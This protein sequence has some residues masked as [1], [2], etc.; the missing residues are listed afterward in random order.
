V[1][2]SG[3]IQ[4]EKPDRGK[5]AGIG[6]NEVAIYAPDGMDDQGIE[7]HLRRN[8]FHVS[9]YRDNQFLENQTGKALEA[10]VIVADTD[11]P[12]VAARVT[13]RFKETPVYASNPGREPAVLGVAKAHDIIVLDPSDEIGDLSRRLGVGTPRS[14]QA[15]PRALVVDDNS[16]DLEDVQKAINGLVD[17]DTA[18]CSDEAIRLLQETANPY[19]VVV[20]DLHLPKECE[21]TQTDPENG[22]AVLEAVRR[23]TP[24][25]QS[26]VITNRFGEDDTYIHHHTAMYRHGAVSFLSK[27]DVFKEP[28]P[29]RRE[30][31][32]AI[33]EYR[34]LSE[35]AG[36]VADVPELVKRAIEASGAIGEWVDLA[37]VGNAMR[38]IHPDF[39]HKTHGFD[40]LS[41][42]IK[43]LPDIVDCDYD[44]SITPPRVMARL[45][46]DRTRDAAPRQRKKAADEYRSLFDFGFIHF[47][48][49]LSALADLA[50]KE[51]WDDESR[52]DKPI[53][54]HY[55]NHTFLRLQHQK[56]ILVY[57]DGAYAVFNTGLVDRVYQPIFAFFTRNKKVDANQPYFLTSFCRAGD[58]GDGQRIIRLFG[59]TPEAAEYFQNPADTVYDLSK[60]APHVNW[61]HIIVD[62]IDRLPVDFIDRYAPKGFPVRDPETLDDETAVRYKQTLQAAIRSDLQSYRDMT[63][64]IQS[65]IDIAMR[66]VRWSFRTAVPSYYRTHNQINLLLPLSLVDDEKT[67]VVL[68][69]EQVEKAYIAHTILTLGQAY[70]QA[71]VVSRP[72]SEWLRL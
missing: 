72:E 11:F 46:S 67:D 24:A 29:L 52:R 36:T 17:M 6:K 12:D 16:V 25:T 2:K 21:S 1:A 65:A 50:L 39:D 45:K 5:E 32:K 42:L 70:R 53:L 28:S 23:M 33:T 19:V 7:E 3:V 49:K 10:I 8:G 40:K 20:C 44:H 35:T 54:K 27:D 69:L 48:T 9:R 63:S 56:K 30:V 58:P 37:T 13:K 71:R 38:Q 14:T 61:D 68:V 59:R 4:S 57:K 41:D 22:L 66:R 34:Q 47:P 55:L 15:L 31:E 60:G 18:G 62:N 26:L 43:S 51:E 64:R